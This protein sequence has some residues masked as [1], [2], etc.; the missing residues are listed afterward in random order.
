ME[1]YKSKFSEA[2]EP[3]SKMANLDEIQYFIDSEKRVQ[4]FPIPDSEG[5]VD[6]IRMEIDFPYVTDHDVYSAYAKLI[7]L[8][9]THYIVFFPKSTSP[10]ELNNFKSMIEMTEGKL[11]KVIILI[12]E[13]Y[14]AGDYT[15]WSKTNETI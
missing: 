3:T 9:K 14:K 13:T 6:S 1:K 2:L 8:G 12:P 7:V 4:V 11:E 10:R 5:I 15:N